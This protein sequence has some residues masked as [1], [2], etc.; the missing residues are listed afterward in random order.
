MNDRTNERTN[1]LTSK[2]MESSA[3][4][5]T[6]R[7]PAGVLLVLSKDESLQ[8][9]SHAVE[10]DASQL[11]GETRLK[12]P[13]E[14]GRLYDAKAF[15]QAL[16][17]LQQCG[18]QDTLQQPLRVG[19][20]LLAPETTTPPAF[21]LAPV[22]LSGLIA[23][24]SAI[25]TA[26]TTTATGAVTPASSL[27]PPPL[28]P[29]SFPELIFTCQSL[30]CAALQRLRRRKR[31]QSL[32]R[33]MM[34]LLLVGLLVVAGQ[35]V[36][37]QSRRAMQQ[38]QYYYNNTTNTT[39]CNN[40]APSSS[41]LQYY[42]ESSAACRL[43]E[44]ALWEKFGDALVSSDNHPSWWELLLSWIPGGTEGANQRQSATFQSFEEY[45]DTNNAPYAMHST[46]TQ[47]LITQSQLDA[48]PSSSSLIAHHYS[49]K[50]AR[51][52]PQLPKPNPIHPSSRRTRL[53]DSTVNRLVLSAV[54][55]HL[56]QQ[57]QQK[58]ST[59]RS[60]TTNK[61]LTILDVGCGVGGTLYALTPLL[62]DYSRQQ[63]QQQPRNVVSY[64]G[65]AV[66]AAELYH[67]QQ[68]YERHHRDM[69][70]EERTPSSLSLNVTFTQHDFDNR[71]LPKDFY[72]VLLAIE[73][74]SYS[75]NLTK[76]LE[77]LLSSLKRGG[78]LLVVDDVAAAAAAP[79]EAGRQGALDLTRMQQ[80]QQQ[81]PSLIPH[82][83]WEALLRDLG[84]P[85]RVGY[86]LTLEYELSHHQRSTKF[87]PSWLSWDAISWRLLL[88]V[89]VRIN[90][91]LGRSDDDA[92]A[93]SRRA[94]EL[95]RDVTELVRRQ[96]LRANAYQEQQSLSYHMY[97]CV[98]DR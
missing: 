63:Q 29:P 96:A 91:W 30:R 54:Q 37:H 43:A 71:P 68:L 72:T 77:S 39:S 40:N 48:T 64:H 5:T 13:L 95:Q 57:Q 22:I 27:P 61:D 90:A 50:V 9:I 56:Q 6:P 4:C 80:Q 47:T 18:I 8:W 59:G 76:T 42:Y 82:R 15:A 87:S 66:S 44:A 75:R 53:G 98:K 49:R 84:C 16:A 7:Q 17:W 60:A 19:R 1:E 51:R 79:S 65:I 11:D 93:A 32:K 88:P 74:L 26:T 41:S 38:L 62:T 81:Q 31:F 23:S 46:L 12:V 33:W 36:L 70:A 3:G 2:Q 28:P 21:A 92:V 58:N 94:L 55:R 97:S 85:L 34:L 20:P 52:Q 24:L 89:A 25:A 35:H 86:D 73:S 14:Q 45:D 83:A 78:V 10:W 67:A 69:E